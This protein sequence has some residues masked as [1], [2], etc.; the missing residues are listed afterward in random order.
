MWKGNNK[1]DLEWARAKR[2]DEFQQIKWKP[3]IHK[4][5]LVPDVRGMVLR[6][7]YPLLENL[8]LKVEVKGRGR[9]I[10][11]SLA[12]GSELIVG[13]KIKVKLSE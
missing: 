8:G 7:V 9:V 4:N 11:Q 12:V 6:D 5:T 2:D 3:V 10:S 1:G 13:S